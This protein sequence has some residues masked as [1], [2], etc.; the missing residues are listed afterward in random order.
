MTSLSAIV[1]H[2]TKTRSLKIRYASSDSYEDN[3]LCMASHR[4]IEG[5]EIEIAYW[6]SKGTEV[7]DI[8]KNIG[9]TTAQ[10]HDA[11]RKIYTKTG[12][13]NIRIIARVFSK[14]DWAPFIDNV[15]LNKDYSFP[16]NIGFSER[17]RKCAYMIYIGLTN[18]EIFK[19]FQVSNRAVSIS[20]EAI[21][22]KLKCNSKKEAR[23]KLNELFSLESDPPNIESNI[24][25]ELRPQHYPEQLPPDPAWINFSKTESRCAQCILQRKRDWEISYSLDMSLLMVSNL[26]DRLHAKMGTKTRLELREKLALN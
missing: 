2:K 5:A 10:T 1:T 22:S 23:L 24:K 14:L 6:L 7:E 21:L 26:I 19:R 20:I 12:T 18:A 9:I 3:V 17:E 16:S 15:I 25:R 13:K 4:F 8:A 11:L